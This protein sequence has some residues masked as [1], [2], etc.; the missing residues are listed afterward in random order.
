MVSGLVSFDS[1]H[2]K[3]KS[4]G[5][6]L[7]CIFTLGHDVTQTSMKSML[8]HSCRFIVNDAFCNSNAFYAFLIF[9]EI[10]IQ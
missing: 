8:M 3:D 4:F 7:E 5:E 1:F 9:F 10:I 6:N 2:Y